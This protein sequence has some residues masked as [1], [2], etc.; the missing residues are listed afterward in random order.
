MNKIGIVRKSTIEARS[1]N[2][3]CRR[4]AVSITYSE[5]VCLSLSYPACKARAP[6]YTTMCGLSGSATLCHKRPGFRG[7]K[8]LLYVKCVVRFSV[9]LSSET[10]LILRRTGRDMIINI[11]GVQVKYRYA[12]QILTFRQRASCILGQA[13]HY[14]PEN[15]FYIFNQQ[16]YF[17]I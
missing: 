13:F 10:F 16:I 4:K 12:C 9:Q 7:K 14:S 11:H 6:Y 8:Y 2:H 17:S 1:P 15:A 5:N 3:C